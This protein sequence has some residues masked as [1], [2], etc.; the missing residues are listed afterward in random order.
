MDKPS[1]WVVLTQRLGY[2]PECWV[3]H[4]TQPLC[5]NNPIAGFVNILPSTG[6]YL[7]QHFL[8]YIFDNY[9]NLQTAFFIEMISKFLHTI[10]LYLFLGKLEKLF[11][12][13]EFILKV[14]YS[15]FIFSKLTFFSIFFSQTMFLSYPESLWYMISVYIQTIID[16]SGCQPMLNL[17]DSTYLALATTFFHKALAVLFINH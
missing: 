13:E 8:V 15:T 2:Y 6:L 9:D 16:L 1:N 14:H 4:L 17:H 11:F 3:K 7:T 5:Q 12:K 10:R